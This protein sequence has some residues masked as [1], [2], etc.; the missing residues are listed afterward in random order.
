MLDCL[1]IPQARFTRHFPHILNKIYKLNVSTGIWFWTTGPA[2]CRRNV[3]LTG[4]PRISET[5]DSK[6]AAGRDALRLCRSGQTDRSQESNGGAQ[7]EG[8]SRSTRFRRT[9]TLE[10]TRTW[11]LPRRPPAASSHQRV[12]VPDACDECATLTRNLLIADSSSLVFGLAKDRWTAQ[13]PTHWN[14]LSPSC[15][16]SLQHL[17]CI[18]IYFWSVNISQRFHKQSLNCWAMITSSVQ[19]VSSKSFRRPR[20]TSRPR[21]E[22]GQ[23]RAHCLMRCVCRRGSGC[24]K[25][26]A[27]GSS[28]SLLHHLQRV[29]HGPTCRR[30]EDTA[31]EPIPSPEP[32]PPKA[33]RLDQCARHTSCYPLTYY[34]PSTPTLH[35]SK[36]L[37]KWSNEHRRT[38]TFYHW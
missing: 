28:P 17:F 36:A 8:S 37:D 1:A 22:E 20:W 35:A 10:M 2:G 18:M 4:I 9:S 33:A 13:I 15:I 19:M 29:L 23:G 14:Q 16:L 3:N 11:R 31:L 25:R 26:R 7:G 34:S 12:R 21:R 27:T 24:S 5:V 30:D 32:A 38:G 6:T